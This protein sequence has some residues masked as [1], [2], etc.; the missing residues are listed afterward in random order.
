M[1]W[2]FRVKNRDFAPKN[3]LSDLHISIKC[4]VWDHKE[5]YSETVRQS[6]NYSH[7]CIP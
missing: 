4:S 7:L 2:V 6:D 1:F 5:D 3:R